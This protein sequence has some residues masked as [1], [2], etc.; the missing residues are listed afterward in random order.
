MTQEMTPYHFGSLRVEADCKARSSRTPTSIMWR[1]PTVFLLWT[2]FTT[3]AVASMPFEG[4]AESSQQSEPSRSQAAASSAAGISHTDLERRAWE[5]VAQGKEIHLPGRC[6]DRSGSSEEPHREIDSALYTLSG[7]FVTKLLTESPSQ[8][9]GH[10][11]PLRIHG[12]RITGDIVISGGAT[13][14]PVDISCSTVEGNIKFQDWTYHEGLELSRVRITGSLKFYD[15]RAKSLVAVTKSDIDHVEVLRSRFANDLSFRGTQVRSVLKIVSTRVQGALLMGCHVS[16]PESCCCASYG[17]TTFL[18]TRITNGLD[19]IGSRFVKD[20]RIDDVHVG[21]SLMASHAIFKGLAASNSN[22][23]GAFLISHSTVQGPF[24]VHTTAVARGMDLRDSTVRQITIR[25]AEI[26]RYMDFRASRLRSL[27]LEDTSVSG[28]L[29]MDTAKKAIDWG[30]SGDGAR[31]VARNTRVD[32]L[33]DSTDSWP[34][35]LSRELNGFEYDKLSGVTDDGRSAYLRG[36]DWFKGW[37]A[38]DETYSPQP[39]RQLYEILMREGQ[40]DAANEIA[41]AAKEQQRRALPLL[42]GERCWLFL[43]RIS[44]GYGIGLKPLRTLCWIL[45]FCIVGWLVAMCAARGQG[46]GFLPL[47]WYSI[48]Y[49]LPGLEGVKDDDLAGLF[50]IRV[51]RWFAIQRLICVL[52]ASLA[53]AAALGLVQP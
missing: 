19:L 29:R 40:V 6:P 21:G 43:L 23:D 32:G 8:G 48:A 24:T 41:Y 22:V 12:A 28:E 17:Q 9:M 16:L 51:R 34:S 4:R 42:S 46:V 49:T 50:S 52:F 30:S 14:V 3:I 44:I 7:P 20:V 2:L 53:G 45:A 25:H 37:L 38:A 26:D 10:P 18:S 39:Y 13:P 15:T 27:I 5:Q 33:R 47:V 35:W 11:A 31:F 36:A 1:H